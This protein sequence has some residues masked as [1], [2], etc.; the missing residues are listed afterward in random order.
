MDSRR[1]TIPG[2]QPNNHYLYQMYVNS[3]GVRTVG[4]W[5]T[6]N[7]ET[8]ECFYKNIYKYDYIGIF[9]SDEVIVP[10]K[11]DNWTQMIKDI[12]VVYFFIKVYLLI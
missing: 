8:I 9:D 7:L 10:K 12:N 5:S 1:L 4:F 2:G 11:A 3:M 6:E